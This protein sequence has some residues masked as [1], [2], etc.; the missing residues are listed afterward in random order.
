M[1]ILISNDDGY[2]SSGIEAL[3]AALAPLGDTVIVAPERNR[4]G[5]SNSLT[6]DAP[7]RVFEAA[8]NVFF[9]N[10]TPTDCV[11]LAVTGLLEPEP[12]MVVSG[13]NDGANLGD[14][15]LYSG[16]VAAAME[17]R[18]LGLPAM[19]VSLVGQRPRRFDTAAR[20]AHMLVERM[21][22]EPLPPETILNVNVPDIGFDQV[23]RFLR[24]SSWQPSS[25]GTGSAGR[26]SQGQA[27]FL[28]WAGRTRTGRRTGHGFSCGWQR[29]CVG[30][31]AA[32]RPDP[33]Y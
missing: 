19:A 25:R 13:V 6:L 1:R 21:A 12:D 10:G 7:L 24:H 20:V 32:G 3:A 26:G 16:T 15:V 29:V 33:A 8:P 5:A 27:D 23:T 11:H 22:R 17:G 30:D 4:S 2:R 31:A 28:G 14:D 18:C 9:V